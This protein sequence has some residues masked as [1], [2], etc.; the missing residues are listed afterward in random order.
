MTTPRR[1]LPDHVTWALE[2]AEMHQARIA[3]L[4][5]EIRQATTDRRGLNPYLLEALLAK[6]AESNAEIG[7]A[8]NAIERREPAPDHGHNGS[9]PAIDRAWLLAMDSLAQHNGNGTLVT[10]RAFIDAKL[11][12][13]EV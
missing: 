13:L 11:K 3:R 7:R 2:L 4:M 8:L 10:I 6:I 5:K 12:E 9:Q 1:K